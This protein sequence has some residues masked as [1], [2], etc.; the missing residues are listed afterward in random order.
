MFKPEMCGLENI[1]RTNLYKAPEGSGSRWWAGESP[2]R[3]SS[4]KLLEFSW[5]FYDCV[6]LVTEITYDL[7]HFAHSVASASRS[8]KKIYMLF[9]L[10]FFLYLGHGTALSRYLV[11]YKSVN[12]RFKD[13]PQRCRDSM[14]RKASQLQGCRG[15]V[16]V[17]EN[18]PCCLLNYTRETELNL[19]HNHKGNVHTL[20]VE[21]S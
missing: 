20:T 12:Y 3:W 15:M 18:D 16:S 11:K 13:I 10:Y 7:L 21:Q 1:K 5:R 19:V 17:E 2:K 8:G 6:F 4:K 9:K 14:P